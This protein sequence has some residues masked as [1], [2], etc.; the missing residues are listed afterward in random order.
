MVFIQHLE[1][2]EKF[3]AKKEKKMNKLRSRRK[4]AQRDQKLMS[5]MFGSNS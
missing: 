4:L 5:N 1:K 3:L 2:L